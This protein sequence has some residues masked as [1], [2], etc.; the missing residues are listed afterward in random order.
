[1]RN[2]EPSLEAI[3]KLRRDG[4]FVHCITNT[5]AQYLTANVL[6]A[7]NASPTMTSSRDEAHAITARADALLVNL[8]MLEPERRRVIDT[9]VIIAANRG[10]PIVLDPVKCELS[11]VRLAFAQKLL[12]SADIILKTN[13]SEAL[14]LADSPTHCRITTGAVDRVESHDGGLVS[15]RNGTPM[16]ARTIATGCAL[17]ALVAALAAVAES[18]ETAA[19]AALVW[20][21]VAAQLADKKAAGPGSFPALLVDALA[22]VDT[23]QLTKKAMVE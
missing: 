11:P 14:V 18:A 1:M 3:A 23:R 21:G 20:F 7:C 16:L 4:A 15:V 12:G 5:V 9:C 6:L 2:I 10:I 13:R 22:S 8:G 19:V 17:G